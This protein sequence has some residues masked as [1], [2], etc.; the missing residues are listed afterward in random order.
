[1]ASVSPLIAIVGETASGKSALAMEIAQVYGGEIICADSRTVY[2]GMDIGTA[3]PTIEDRK[4][5]RH[6]LL[7]VVHPDEPFT[8]ADFKYLAEQAIADIAS[9]GKIPLLVGGTGLYVDSVLY[10]FQFLAPGDPAE[11]QRLNELSVPE[12][13]ELMAE[14]GIALPENSQNPRHLVRAL[15]TNGQV[16]KRSEL[17]VNTLVMGLSP[18][19]EQ[20]QKRIIE[21]VNKM[22]QEGL[23]KEVEHLAQRYSWD[24]DAIRTPGYRAFGAYVRGEIDLDEAKRLFATSDRQ[25][26]KRQRTWFKRNK[27]IQWVNDT[28]HAKE[29]VQNF[30]SNHASSS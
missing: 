3:K 5:V 9:R 7:D 16:A 20:L 10:D 28:D 19:R 4:L 22:V 8:A 2:K 14:R 13:H 11:R 21:R 27:S 18:E 17:R 30:L 29:L 24:L 12:L 1:M 6:H 25:L 15:E 26:A 23:V